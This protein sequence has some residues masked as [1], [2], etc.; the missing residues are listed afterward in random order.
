MNEIASVIARFPNHARATRHA[1]DQLSGRCGLK[2]GP[3]AW[4]GCNRRATLGVLREGRGHA[5]QIDH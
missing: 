2:D 3:P 1:N 4:G 5:E